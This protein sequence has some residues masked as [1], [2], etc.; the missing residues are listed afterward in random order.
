MSPLVCNGAARSK[1]HGWGRYY[2]LMSGDSTIGKF[3]MCRCYKGVASIIFS[4]DSLFSDDGLVSD[5]EQGRHRCTKRKFA[6]FIWGK[7]VLKKCMFEFKRTHVSGRVCAASAVRTTKSLLP[8]KKVRFRH[9]PIRQS[10][11]TQSLFF[12]LFSLTL[13]RHLR[14]LAH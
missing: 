13:D 1:A 14:P 4:D 10:D 8:K 9:R 2:H 7:G 3:G 5:G 11:E 12:R 6:L